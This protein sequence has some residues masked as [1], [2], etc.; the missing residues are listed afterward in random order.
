MKSQEEVSAKKE[1]PVMNVRQAA[2]KWGVSIR[3]VSKLCQD[4]R[5]E[6]AYKL[7]ARMWLIPA[8]AKKPQTFR[9]RP[10]SSGRWIEGGEMRNACT[11]N[12]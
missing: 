4:G 8:D 10:R 12:N 11:E 7:S 3:R 5:V 2:E 6:G 9:G 1:Y